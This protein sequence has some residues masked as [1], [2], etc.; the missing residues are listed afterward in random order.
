MRVS[1]WERD[2]AGNRGAAVLDA[3]TSNLASCEVGGG[4]WYAPWT[5]KAEMQEPLGSLAS[6]QVD[7]QGIQ[8]ALAPFIDAVPGL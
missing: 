3:A 6:V 4:P 7:V 5:G 2:A 1:I 8:S